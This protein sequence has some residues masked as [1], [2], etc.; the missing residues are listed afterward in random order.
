[1]ARDPGLETL[2]SEDLAEVAPLT[3]KAMFGGMAWLLDGRLLCAASAR[4]IM[5]RLGKGNDAWALARP[6]VTAMQMQ[7]RTMSGWIRVA[8]ETCA[9][10][11]LRRR[12]LT[13]AITFVRS[14]PA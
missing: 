6:G 12:L 2:L 5:V 13:Q 11:D 10:D 7:G 8:P 1:M 14:L 3:Q 9:S 4:G